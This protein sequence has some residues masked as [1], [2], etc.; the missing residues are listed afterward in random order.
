MELK[1]EWIRFLRSGILSESCLIFS[2]R[3]RVGRFIGNIKEKYIFSLGYMI[4][5]FFLELKFNVKEYFK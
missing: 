1:W 2:F 3:F 5:L 4:F